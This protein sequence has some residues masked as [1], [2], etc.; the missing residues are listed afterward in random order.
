MIQTPCYFDIVARTPTICLLIPLDGATI[1]N[2]GSK[3]E[4]LSQ[5]AVCRLQ[6]LLGL[7]YR[8][9]SRLRLKQKQIRK[10]S[11]FDPNRQEALPS[12]SP[13]RSIDSAQTPKTLFWQESSKQGQKKSGYPVFSDPEPLITTPCT[14]EEFELDHRKYRSMQLRPVRVSCSSRS[15]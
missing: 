3:W 12:D 5:N 14:N 11:K 15:K 13:R 6:D 8:F 4:E 10:R 2:L 9:K 1:T 7:R